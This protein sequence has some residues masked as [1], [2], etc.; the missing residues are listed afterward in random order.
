MIRIHC[1]S[2]RSARFGRREPRAA[3]WE[4]TGLGRRTERRTL[5]LTV[6]RRSHTLTPLQYRAR[7][8]GDSYL[9]AKVALGSPCGD[10]VNDTPPNLSIS[11]GR[12]SL[13]EH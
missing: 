12:L 1:G 6:L 8:V 9:H 13:H 7:K 2:D 5:H 11:V 4:A 10:Y 3:A